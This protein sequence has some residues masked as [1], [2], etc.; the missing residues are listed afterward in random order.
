MLQLTPFEAK[1]TADHIPSQALL[2]GY[3][4]TVHFTVSL[5]GTETWPPAEPMNQCPGVF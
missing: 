5:Q 4:N 2:F 1:P 3:R